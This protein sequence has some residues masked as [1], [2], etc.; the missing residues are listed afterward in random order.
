MWAEFKNFAFKGNVIDLAI[1]IVIGA[2][3]GL[4]VNSFVTDLISPLIGLFG[5][6]AALENL[7]VQLTPTVVLTYGAFLN[8]LLNFVIVALA[9]FL[10]IKGVNRFRKAVEVTERPC[11][12]CLTSIPK[13]ASRCPSCTSEVTPE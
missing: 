11:P 4:V 13:A 5:G 1:G 8:A 12:Y 6:K 3:F 2:A 7:S 10:I 9:L